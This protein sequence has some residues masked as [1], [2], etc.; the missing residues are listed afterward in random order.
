MGSP[1][2]N[3]QY[4]PPRLSEDR[5]N[6]PQPHSPS[7]P[8][9]CSGKSGMRPFGPDPEPGGCPDVPDA[10]DDGLVRR[11]RGAAPVRRDVT[12][13]PVLDLVP[14]AGAGWKMTHLDGQSGLV[15]QLL[16]L[17]L[18]GAQPIP[19]APARIGCD[20]QGRGLGVGPQPI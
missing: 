14:L 19:V 7:L 5:L 20:E 10:V 13:E 2:R 11:Q 12:E 9:H 15:G 17:M 16:K 6:L 3:V 18:P 4:H 1:S 8:T